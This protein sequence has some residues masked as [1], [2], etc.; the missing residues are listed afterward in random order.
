M[1]ALVLQA[2]LD[3]LRANLRELHRRRA[4]AKILCAAAVQ[5]AL[6]AW[7]GPLMGWSFRAIATLFGA[8]LVVS[9]LLSTW[10]SR[11]LRW[12]DIELARMIET[13]H[14]D[15]NALLLT[16][17]EQLDPVAGEN[18]FRQRL[19]DS[20]SE[21]GARTDWKSTVTSRGLRWTNWG[22]GAAAV[23]CLL[24][25][26]FMIVK[27]PHAAKPAAQS[28]AAAAA[29]PPAPLLTA[30]VT[31]GD[32][33]VE[34][35]TRLI[36]EARFEKDVPAEATLIISEPDGAERERVPMRLTVDQQVFGG[37]IAR[38]DQ[39]AKYRVAFG[40][41]H[42]EEFRISTFVYPALE[43]ADVRITPPAYS[44]LP[45]KEIKNTLKVS[46]LEH[47][48][49]AFRFKINKPVKEAELFAEDKTILPL[50]PLPDDPTILTGI[51]KAEKTQKWRLHLVDDKERANKN[52]PWI[53]ITVQTNQLAK[54]EVVFPK[55]DIQI[56]ALQEL[57][58]EAKIWDDLGVTKSGASY[59]IAGKT[60]DVDFK[61]GTTSA[62]KKAE[63]KALL[64]ME[65]EN[66]EPRQLVSYYFWAEDKGPKGEVRRAMSD[67]FFADVRHFEDI[68]RE[69]EAPPGKP[70][71]P[72]KGQADKL[73]ELQKQVV[74]ATWRLIRDTQAG[75]TMEAATPDVDVVHESQ[76][77]ALNQTKEAMEEVEDAEVK[78]SL[79]EAW[80]SMKDA[81]D[82]LRQASE[83]KKK[84]SLN[85]ALTFEQSALEWLHR[86]QSREHRVMRQK[87]PSKGAGQQ[88]N[89]NQLMNLELKQQDERYEE[90]K[91]ATEE[92]TAEQQENLQVL[93]RLKE[94]ARRQEALAEKMKE[95]ENQ[96]AKAKT[97]EERNELANQLQ[98]LQDEQE[99]LLRDLDDL[100][101]RM[102]KPE[103]ASNMAEA[104]EQLEQTREQVM[105]AAE[106][107]KQQQLADAANAATRAQ[108]ELEKMQEDFRQKT[109]KRFADEMKQLR[110]ESREANE[111]QKQ[112]SE[113]LEN[114]KTPAESKDTTSSL[115]KML[116]GSQV[117]RQIEEQQGKLKQLLEN[118]RRI[119][120]EAEG[121]NPL[122]HRNL[123]EAV[124]TAQTGG[125]E[126]NLQEARDQAR[127][128]NR[129]DAQEAERKATAS[130]EQLQK[131]VEKAAESVLGNETEA[132]R[133]ARTELDKLLEEV[134]SEEKNAKAAPGAES[135]APPSDKAQA[136][137]QPG[138]TP[139]GG[140]EAKG[141]GAEG[142][143]TA[144][145]ESSSKE[146]QQPG[147]KEGS[148]SG[149]SQ[150]PGGQSK[151]EPN[152]KGQPGKVAGEATG[153][154]EAQGKG[155]GQGQEPGKGQ[156]KQPGGSSEG[157]QVAGGPGEPTDS[158]PKDGGQGQ[159][160]G[161][162]SAG[163]AA[164]RNLAGD[165]RRGNL[166]P[167]GGGGNQGGFFFDEQTETENR[168][169]LT[170]TGYDQWTD[171]LRNVEELLSEPQLRNEAAKVLDNARA[172]RVDH[173]RNNMAPQTDHLQMRITQPLVELRDRVAE[174]L[175]KRDTGNPMVPVDRDPVPPAFRELVRR[176]YTELGAGK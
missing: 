84:A 113:A 29:T 120:E 65:Q 95:L 167:G 133:M 173:E 152:Q 97:E 46:A 104:K 77:I 78:T 56:S 38:V 110:A 76:E 134:R 162:P 156:G 47:S 71:D 79:T 103:N 91:Q 13:R 33:E 58:V 83:E 125:L 23:L 49:I 100:K 163:G 53:S 87:Q 108:R 5:A 111:R 124:R 161:N 174:E 35:G 1:N 81:L 155:E 55:R 63:V 3:G 150:K 146:G 10:W 36:V 34:R 41:Q 168:A 44:G 64:A 73:V 7:V 72:P 147:G 140:Q 115:E 99:Q 24:S 93:N 74:N 127:Y 48:D 52:P 80:K 126:D 157:G 20:A 112:I 144:A 145:T 70:G 14:P 119:S 118:M 128:G 96:M 9:G 57:P 12:S 148:P 90:E 149:E 88:A 135:A 15:L 151:G 105:D 40:E 42:S 75:R 106:K 45:A 107:L 137:N 142:K 166:R 164:G 89:Q 175:A 98:R 94:L 121:N 30:T 28:L 169:P 59:S 114:Q 62:T 2:K 67:M 61:H 122:L 172:M 50:K 139:K 26:G 86:A 68:F 69:S 17:V 136:S 37:L 85:Q 109:A 82:P 159:A 39:D 31:P 22:L 141:K 158:A 27:R 92:Q 154:G 138:E 18:L 160:K 11:R 60:K 21:H 130:V 165:D 66:A 170:G 176:Y 32:T 43:R 143:Q 123:Y 171:R 116:D 131:G 101:E 19:L 153:Q 117:A 54:I 16:A 132:L 8:A 129:T 25:I 4:A 102:E 6:L 51:L